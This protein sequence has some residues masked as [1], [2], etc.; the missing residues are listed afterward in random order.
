M[1]II[2]QG[3]ALLVSGMTIVYLFLWLLVIV[4]NQATKLV[5]KFNHILPDDEPKK[6]HRHA[7]QQQAKDHTAVAVA[8]AGAIAQSR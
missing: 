6:K 7:A 1:D 8:I 4:M 3:F 2:L 5:S